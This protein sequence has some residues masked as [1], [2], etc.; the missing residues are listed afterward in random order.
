MRPG[1]DAAGQAKPLAA[2]VTNAS[3]GRIRV[4]LMARNAVTL[5]GEVAAKIAALPVPEGGSFSKGQP[6]VQF[7]CGSYRAQLRKSRLRWRPPASCSR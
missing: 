7:D 3:D 6:L 5:S 4:Q 1:G 2:P